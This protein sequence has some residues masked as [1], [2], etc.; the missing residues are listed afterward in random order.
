MS[1]NRKISYFN[2]WDSNLQGDELVKKEAILNV[3]NSSWAGFLCI[4]A[5]SSITRSNINSFYPD[6]GDQKYRCLFTQNIYPRIPL[7]A[8][9]PDLNILFCFEGAVVSGFKPNHFV[10]VLANITGRKIKLSSSAVV[11]F[12]PNSHFLL[13]HVLRKNLYL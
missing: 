4:L 1:G 6:T 12:N 13:K 3:E 10:P 9:N 5:L 8:V 11:K 2:P 7:K